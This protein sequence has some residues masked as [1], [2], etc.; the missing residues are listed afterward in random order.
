MSAVFSPTDIE[1]LAR[2][3][4]ARAWFAELDL[5]SGLARLHNGV[6]RVSVGG[7]EWLGVTDPLGGRM[8]AV[9]GVEEPVFGQA[10]AVMI[11]LTGANK[12]FLQ[13]VHATARQI[14]GRDASIYWAAFD[15]ETQQILIEP[16]LLFPR[17]KMTAPAIQWTGIG[18]R[19]VT[20][21]IE[22]IWSAKNFAPGGRWNAADQK[23]RYPG[24]RG[25]EFI[26]VTVSEPL[27]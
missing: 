12:A 9:T 19:L 24:D 10:A 11:T 16:K 7:Y 25:G 3:H 23:R 21:T 17:G 14:E 20:L 26:G 5:P 6:G 2:P 13:S 18:V 1:R 22:S 27:K 4:V 15:G 8:V